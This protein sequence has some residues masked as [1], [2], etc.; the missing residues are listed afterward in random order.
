LLDSR[1]TPAA[2]T[3][4]VIIPALNEA[5]NIGWVLQRIPS[6]VDEVIVV[7]G[8]S[9]DGTLDVAK[10]IRADVIA[11]KEL[12]R[13][14]GVA[15]RAGF[16]AARG[17]YLVVMDADGSMDPHEIGR[18]V[19][20]LD[21][22]YELVKGSRYLQGGGSSDL[23]AYRG[24]GNS[25]LRG[26][27]NLL[28]RTDFT[29]LCYGYF[30][31]RRDTLPRL[32]LSADGFEIET[33]VVVRAVAAGLRVAEV[34]SFETPRRHGESNLH[35]IRDGIRIVRELLRGRARGMLARAASPML[36]PAALETVRVV[37]RGRR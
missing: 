32:A 19:D 7:D 20:A 22:G 13:G 4:S 28:F 10:R 17:D 16:A 31:L 34:P 30:A 33:Q 27:A 6:M 5:E 8:L 12:R 36:R 11:V 15:M 24:L 35:P 21:S 26:F 18:Y 2:P 25:A 9:H 37:A 1:R 23:T 3:V 29:E 14:K